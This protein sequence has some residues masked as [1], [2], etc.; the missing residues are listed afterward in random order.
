V[1]ADAVT[2][3]RSGELASSGPIAW[4]DGIMARHRPVVA[5]INRHQVLQAYRGNRGIILVRHSPDE[6]YLLVHIDKERHGFVRCH[7]HYIRPVALAD[8]TPGE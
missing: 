2:A 3:A 7:P 4:P 1:E 5:R 8:P 6:L